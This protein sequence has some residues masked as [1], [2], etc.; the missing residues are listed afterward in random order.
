LTHISTA[1]DEEAMGRVEEEKRAA[2]ERGTATKRARA[3]L[4][5]ARAGVRRMMGVRAR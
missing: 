2:A 1:G 3:A 4:E 5:R